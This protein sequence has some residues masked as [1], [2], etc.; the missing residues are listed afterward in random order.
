MRRLV[1]QIIKKLDAFNKQLEKG[2]IKWKQI[3]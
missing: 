1:K 2:A 3:M